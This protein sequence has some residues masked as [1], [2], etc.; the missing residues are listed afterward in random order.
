MNNERFSVPEVIFRPDDIGMSSS[1]LTS[2]YL[3]IK[4]GYHRIGPIRPGCHHRFV[5]LFPTSGSS[6]DVLGEHRI[7]WW[8][9]QISRVPGKT[10]RS[11]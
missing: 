8:K 10:V 5:D 11:P 7:D 9:Y 2:F 6:R 3:F 4:P 1:H